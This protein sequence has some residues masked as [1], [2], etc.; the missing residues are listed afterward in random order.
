[1]AP[2]NAVS[3]AHELKAKVVGGQLTVG[4]WET[5]WRCPSLGVLEMVGGGEAVA[6]PRDRVAMASAGCLPWA[7]LCA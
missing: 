5:L 1:M 6:E 7:A 2:V 4:W 3:H